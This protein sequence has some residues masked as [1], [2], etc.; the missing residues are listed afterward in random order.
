VFGPAGGDTPR[1]RGALVLPNPSAAFRAACGESC[2]DGSYFL[3]L[4]STNLLVELDGVRWRWAACCAAGADRI[5]PSWQAVDQI[6]PAPP[7]PA[8]R[9]RICAPARALSAG[10]DAMTCSH[11]PA[12]PAISVFR[13]LHDAPAAAPEAPDVP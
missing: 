13:S 2:R 11:R 5:G 1:R 12:R 6:R 3:R 4:I 8:V 10:D 9:G 7:R